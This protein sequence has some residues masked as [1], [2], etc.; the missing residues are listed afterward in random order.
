MTLTFF[1]LPINYKPILHGELHDIVFYGRGG[2]SWE[3]AYNWPIWLRKFYLRKI[4]ESYKA[5]KDAHN[6]ANENAGKGQ[7]KLAKPNI[8]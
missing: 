8:R 4:Q 5:E 1:G 2:Y 7:K 3:T 6:K